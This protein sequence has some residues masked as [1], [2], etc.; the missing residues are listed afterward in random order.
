MFEK[1]RLWLCAVLLIAALPVGAQRH[2]IDSLTRE[3][4]SAK[5]DSIRWYYAIQLSAAYLRISFD[6]SKAYGE[7]SLNLAGNLG[8]GACKARSLNTLGATYWAKGDHETALHNYFESLKIS[9]PG[10]MDLL[11]ST[12]LGNIGMVYSERNDVERSLEYLRRALAKKQALHDTLGLVRTLN[13]IGRTFFNSS[14]HDSALVYFQQCLPLF[15]VLPA[16]IMG[17]AIV[18]NNLGAIY[19]NKK[20][21]PKARDFFN[22][23][24]AI[25]EKLQ[26]KGGQSVVLSNLG[27]LA[28][29]EGKAAE[30]IAY[31]ERSLALSR[32]TGSET[33]RAEVWKKLSEAYAELNNHPKA[34]GYLLK[35]TTWQ[36]TL[37]RRESETR[38]A[39]ME[40]KYQTGIKEAEIAKQQLQIEREQ[41][42]QRLLIIIALAMLLALT[43]LFQYLRNRHRLR[44]REAEHSLALRDAEAS[45]LLELDRIKSSFFANISHEFRTP[46]T[47]ILGPV[48]KWLAEHPA[49][50][51]IDIPAKDLNGIRRNAARLLDLVNQL[52]DLSKIESGRMRVAVSRDDL[53]QTLRVL[54]NAFESMAEQGNIRYRIE[55]PAESALAWFDRDKLEKIT[56]NLLS[57]AFKHTPPGGTVTLHAELRDD[58]LH[59]SVQDNGKGIPAEELNRIFERFYQ[60]EGSGDK[61]TGIGL[62]LVKELVALHHG[63][64]SVESKLGEGSVFRVTLPVG[65][66]MFAADEIV[67]NTVPVSVQEFSGKMAT[68]QM[69]QTTPEETPEDPALPL[70]L[71]VEDNPELQVFI[72][73]QLSGHF[74]VLLAANGRIGLDMAT[75]NIPDLVISDVMMPE[76]D[77]N[78]L[79]AA[80][81]TD[82]RTSHIP[83]ILL[84]AKA[85]QESRLEGLETGADDYLTKPFDTRELLVRANNLIAQRERLRKQF[86]RTVV[87]KPKDIALTSADERFLQRIQDSL[88]EHLGNEQFNVEELAAGVGM[89][90][91]QL[92]RK[93]TALIDQPPVEFI[94]NFRLRRAKEMLEAGTGNV[95]E[96]CYDV[97][98]SSPAYF[99]KAFKEA[100]GMSPSELRKG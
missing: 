66:G 88:D 29:A 100:F 65:W 91:S 61:G 96:I 71:V 21:Y 46:L 19:L 72:R 76:M 48:Q 34:Y 83:V 33:D 17:K 95:S 52:L 20:D 27:E 40:V 44:Q 14:Q 87:L 43:G 81:K 89:S 64:I 75:E 57:N 26:D 41:S 93:L 84:T 49:V 42:R 22:Q 58:Q 94:R 32:E 23:S 10:G 16:Q 45:R 1:T 90:R 50:P 38:I 62:A 68:L 28:L 47:L 18:L 9:E 92:H 63:S 60:V 35:Y 54:G 30:S 8:K 99:S 79:C 56:A 86:S 80:L 12:T 24:L 53:T 82:E 2:E 73:D 98:F 25:R 85:G 36:D 51:V 11:A 97:G 78:Q 31:Y 69:P 39:D 6:T 74:R 67:E 4:A 3:L 55:I 59:L 70:C 15:D 37:H 13:N 5:D 77:G 7:Q